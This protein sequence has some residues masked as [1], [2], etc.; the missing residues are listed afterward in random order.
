MIEHNCTMSDIGK[1]TINSLARKRKIVTGNFN[2]FNA[3]KIGLVRKNYLL[4]LLR[5]NLKKETEKN[6]FF[7]KY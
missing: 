2:L 6:V 4:N 7:A 5:E 1:G 3:L